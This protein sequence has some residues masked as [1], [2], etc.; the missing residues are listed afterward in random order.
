LAPEKGFR[1]AKFRT[2]SIMD[3][4]AAEEPPMAN[5]PQPGPTVVIV[6]MHAELI[7]LRRLA[8]T[9]ESFSL[10]RWEA[11]DLT[12]GDKSAIAIHSEIGMLNAAAAT[13]RTIAELHPARILNYGCAGAHHR[14]IN[15]GDVILGERTV[16]GTSLNILRDGSEVHNGRGY[17]VSTDQIYPAI[18]DTDP[19]LLASAQ[20][21]AN[22]YKIEPWPGS[23]IAP[24]LRLGPVLSS[25]IWTQSLERLDILH[26][27]HGSLAEDMEAA[28]IA[29]V[30][31]IHDISFLTIKDISNNEYHKAS[32]LAEF[33]DFPVEEIGKRAATFTKSLLTSL[34]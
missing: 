21:I 11:F 10:D 18:I 17:G 33:T 24:R 5:P 26:D 2:P 8:D 1:F 25:D 16:N 28:A 20:K 4:I 23:D 13:E 19:D 12:F 15:P 27:R 14:D 31:L 22:G 29:H 6:A 34:P 9:E 30:C 7:H 3:R 32:D